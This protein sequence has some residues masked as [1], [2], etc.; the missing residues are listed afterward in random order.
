MDA[1]PVRWHGPHRVVPPAAAPSAWGERRSN[2]SY[3][4]PVRRLALLLAVTILSLLALEGI[5]R[6]GFADRFHVR[7]EARNLVYD[8]DPELGW[9]P[10]PGSERTMTGSRSFHVQHNSRGFRDPEPGP[11]TRPRL[12]VLGDSYVWGFDAEAEERFTTRLQERMPGW[13][14]LNLG[15]S[16]Y[17]TDQ[18]LLLLEEHIDFYEP[19][20]VFLVFTEQN[21]RI[22]NTHNRVY[23]HYYKPYFIEAAGEFELRGTPVPTPLP[24]L[25]RQYP[26]LSKSTLATALVDAWIRIRNPAVE[27]PDRSEQLVVAVRDLAHA[28]GAGFAFGIEG[29][30]PDWPWA[31]LAREHRIPAVHLNTPHR[32]PEFGGHWTPEGH[33]IVAERIY[34]LLQRRGWIATPSP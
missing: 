28:R 21:D 15:V 10:E 19:D 34:E 29:Q 26:W 13:E 16:G 12:A 25:Q 8:F 27:V 11:K 3:H 2:F 30:H 14:V 5:L 7:S 9:F 24:Y 4:N 20:V 18:A 33:E 32:Y 1:P 31:D 6:V 23:E 22:D 17:G